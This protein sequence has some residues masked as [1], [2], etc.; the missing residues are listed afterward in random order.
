MARVRRRGQN[1]SLAK[2]LQGQ[3]NKAVA[4]AVQQVAVE[5]TNGLAQ[6]GPAWSGSFSSAWDVVI[7]GGAASPPRKEG[8]VYS[9][10]KRNFPLSRYERVLNSKVGS[11]MIR[12]EITNSS[13]Y[14][15]IAIDEEEGLFFA[16]GTPIKPVIERG[17]RRKDGGGMQDFGLRPDIA[18]GYTR[19][20][21]NASITA[22]KF[23]FQTYTRGGQLSFNVRRGVEIGFRL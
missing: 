12:F 11:D 9:Y 16:I 20:D 22:P 14:A 13:P 2:D 17:F 23:W 19:E 3:I 10:N 8:S 7:P 1:I 18:I 6:A 4:K 5:V 15:G 21:P